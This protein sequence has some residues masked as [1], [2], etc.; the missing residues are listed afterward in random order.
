MNT[1]KH[2]MSIDEFGLM[3]VDRI[4]VL[5]FWCLLIITSLS[6]EQS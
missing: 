6:L 1:D 4:A 3:A 5:T 2:E